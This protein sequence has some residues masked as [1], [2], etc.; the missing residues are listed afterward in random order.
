MAGQVFIR[1]ENS[2]ASSTELRNFG[3]VVGTLTAGLFG[4]ALPWLSRRAFPIWPCALSG[5]LILPAL[6][7]PPALRYVHWVW[8]RIGFIL[9]WINSRII[10]TILFFLVIVPMGLL[11]RLLG[12]DPVARKL[13]P[14]ATSY[15]TAS[16]QRSRESMERP[17]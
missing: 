8:V 7:W 9:G 2:A 14:E 12:H 5:A 4:L 16:R 11:M 15:R 3:L 1:K 10:L 6:L 13:D 17:F